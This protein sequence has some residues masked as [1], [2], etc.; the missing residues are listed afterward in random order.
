MAFNAGVKRL[1]TVVG[2]VTLVGALVVGGSA[3]Y[4]TSGGSSLSDSDKAHLV[5]AQVE[6]DW[7]VHNL[8]CIKQPHAIHLKSELDAVLTPTGSSSSSSASTS[9]TVTTVAPPSTTAAPTTTTV[10]ST[11]TTARPT[12]TGPVGV[13][14]TWISTFGDEFNGT[15]LDRTK[16]NTFGSWETLDGGRWNPGNGELDY[17]TDGQNMSFANGVATFQSRRETSAEP[18]AQW[19]GAQLGSKQA[20]TYGYIETRAQFSPT[21]GIQPALWTW[22][23]PGTNA[24]AQE[25]DGY[26]FY[27]DNHTW[28][29]LNSHATGGGG[30]TIHLA[31]DPT[32]GMHIYGT[33]IESTGT[34]W[35]V[36]GVH[37]CHAPGHPTQPW[38]IVDYSVVLASSRAPTVSPSTTHAEY[39]ADYVRAWSH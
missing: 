7:L 26:E 17:K 9:T 27:G 36:D 13:S 10:P 38:N 39:F 28:L 34:D 4:S 29:Y 22:G 5:A 21:T 18:N 16:W 3:A 31:F 35:Y 23:A 19:T 12:G 15:S 14:G 30:C 11:T 6:A 33:D 24:S 1:V 8:C 37:V 20:F 32:V 2:T 25:T